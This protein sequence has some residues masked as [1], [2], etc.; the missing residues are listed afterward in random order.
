MQGNCTFT[1]EK[2]VS[3]AIGTVGIVDWTTDLPGLTKADVVFTLDDAMAD[4]LNTGDT[5]PAVLTGSPYRTLLLGLK[6][7]RNYTFHIVASA[8]ATVCTSPDY[9]LTTGS[10]GAGLPELEREVPLAAERARGFLITS[11]GISGFGGGGGGGGDPMAFILDADGDVVWWAA[12]PA[13]CSRA[14]MS[15]EGTDMW[16]LEL[17]V[18]NQGGEMARV[19]MDGLDVEGNVQGLAETHHDFTVLP[20][21]IVAAPSWVSGGNDPPS[22]LIERSP[23]GTIDVVFTIDETIY[24]SNTY[25]A[26]GISYI[27]ADDSYTISDRN[28]NLFVKV[29]RQGQLLW[30]FGGSCN[31]APA[32]KCAG[33]DWQVNHGHHLLPNGNLVFF[34]NGAGGGDSAVLEYSL[35]ETADSLVAMPVWDYTSNVN[36]MVLGDAQRLPN[37]NTLVTYSASGVIHEVNPERQL[38]QSFTSN[39]F[40]YSEFR[41]SLYGAPPR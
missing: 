2:S 18:D 23:D 34:N 3:K 12:A 14:R 20:G 4:E 37:G 11:T 13:S 25:H 7:Q 8:G 5:A 1:V 21:G 35:M 15:Y 10:V 22:D 26:N 24:Q 32:P 6:P 41:T 31:N 16:M 27:P 29:N 33:G 19:S 9:T 30:Q 17:N 36:S 39:A 40:G 28:P 38:V